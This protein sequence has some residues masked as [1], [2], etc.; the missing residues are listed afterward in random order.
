MYKCQSPSPN[1]SWLIFLSLPCYFFLTFPISICRRASRHS[2]WPSSLSALILWMT[3]SSPVAF[4]TVC[5]LVTSN[6]KSPALSPSLTFAGLL[7]ML[8]GCLIGIWNLTH[9]TLN[10]H[11][12]LQGCSPI[13]F[14]PSIYCHST[15]L[16]LWAKNLGVI[17][18]SPLLSHTH[19]WPLIKSCQFYLHNISVTQ[20]LATSHYSYPWSKP[21]HWPPDS[22]L[23]YLV[24]SQQSIHSY[25][26]KWKNGASLVA[27]WLRIHLLI[28]GTQ[29]QALVR[30]DPTC[31]GGTK[32]V[33][34]N[35]RPCVLE[36][37][38]HNYWGRVP[39]ILKPALLE[40]GLRDKPLQREAHAPF[41]ETKACAQQQRPNAAINLK[42][43][44]IFKKPKN[45]LEKKLLNC[46]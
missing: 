21:P 34:H 11:L 5:V 22:A 8:L 4:N 39:Q 3:S 28:Q 24:Y 1:S 36:P 6:F 46:E 14:L 43:K 17:P 10:P 20:N 38:S 2:P 45:Y 41:T 31:H 44:I 30:E 33:R 25:P 26:L 23:D 35:Y 13:I 29:V 37:A 19:I 16:V 9:Q 12:S 18:D 7:A 15:F 32:P 40:P 42:K 27:R